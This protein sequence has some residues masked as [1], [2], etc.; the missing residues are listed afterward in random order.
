[1]SNQVILNGGPY[2]GSAALAFTSLTVTAGAPG[3]AFAVV[4]MRATPTPSHTEHNRQH[5][6]SN[7]LRSPPGQGHCRVQ[8]TAAGHQLGAV[9][10]ERQAVPRACQVRAQ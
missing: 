9:L 8:L 3:G 6:G 4:S 10:I 5:T 1:M 7:Q 2:L